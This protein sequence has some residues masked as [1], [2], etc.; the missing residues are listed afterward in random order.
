MLN[1]FV[2]LVVEVRVARFMEL[3]NAELSF[4]K[5]FLWILLYKL[6]YKVCQQ[7]PD[8]QNNNS[9]KHFLKMFETHK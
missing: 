1:N 4:S 2:D 9:K 3:E 6:I 5:K 7:K 8:A